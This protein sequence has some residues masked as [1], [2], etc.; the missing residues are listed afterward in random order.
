MISLVVLTRPVL[1]LKKVKDS[2]AHSL[3]QPCQAP[4]SVG[5][6]LYE[7]YT[8]LSPGPGEGF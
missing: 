5:S 7:M 8:I 1:P 2:V 3:F 4:R 6:E